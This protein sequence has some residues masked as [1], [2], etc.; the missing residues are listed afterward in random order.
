MGD[1]K[2]LDFYAYVSGRY[3]VKRENYKGVNIEIYHAPQHGFDVDDMIEGA[4]SGLDYYQDNY[5]PYQFKQFRILEF[6]RYR[7]F[8]QSFPNTS[9]SPKPS[10]SRASSIRRRTSTLLI[11]SPRMSWRTSGGAIS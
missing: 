1:V 2:I 10:G 6:P 5:S 7:Q 3:D 8:A 11:S 9:P 4:K